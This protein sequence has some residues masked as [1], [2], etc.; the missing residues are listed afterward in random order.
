MLY[1]DEALGLLVILLSGFTG[2]A[3]ENL[4]FAEMLGR[5][6]RYAEYRRSRRNCISYSAGKP[7]GRPRV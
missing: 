6:A 5:K 7:A 2:T 1:A 3:R 4:K